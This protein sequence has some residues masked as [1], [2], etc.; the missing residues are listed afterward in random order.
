MFTIL[1]ENNMFFLPYGQIFS[2]ILKTTS[3]FD[4]WTDSFP[5]IKK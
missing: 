1:K 4:R 5:N 2:G 3:I